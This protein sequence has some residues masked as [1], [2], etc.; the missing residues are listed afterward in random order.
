[1]AVGRTSSTGLPWLVASSDLTNG[2][3]IIYPTS[4][5]G[6]GV[7]LSG[8]AVNFTAATTV[9]LNGV[10][11]SSYENYFVTGFVTDASVILGCRIRMRASSTDNSSANYDGSTDLVAASSG[12]VS[13]SDGG[14]GGTYASVVGLS[15]GAEG[16]S[17]A[18]T[19]LSPQLV[20]RT[21]ILIN[22]VRSAGLYFGSSYLTV[23]TQYDGFSFYSSGGTMSGTIRVYGLRNS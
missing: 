12:G 10:F 7:T 23:T 4:V 17:F 16:S 20:R 14:T 15:S 19:F 1:M 11:T 18:V 2:S 22:A 5:A 13:Q 8:G 3:D 6:A 21:G 9:S